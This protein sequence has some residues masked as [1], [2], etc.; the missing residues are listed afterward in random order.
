MRQ[1][2]TL[3]EIKRRKHKIYCSFFWK[4]HKEIRRETIP[5]FEFGSKKEEK[6]NIIISSRRDT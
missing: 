5:L 3:C 6:M 2:V 1:K 4:T